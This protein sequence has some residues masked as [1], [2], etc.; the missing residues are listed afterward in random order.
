MLVSKLD[1]HFC[2]DQPQYYHD[3]CL[4]REKKDQNSSVENAIKEEVMW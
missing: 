4:F 1:K 2:V 3:V